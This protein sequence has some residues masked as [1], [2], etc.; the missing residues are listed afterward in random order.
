MSLSTELVVRIG[1]GT[2]AGAAHREVLWKA[3][4]RVVAR[5]RRVFL[6]SALGGALIAIAVGI[7]SAIVLDSEFLAGL[8]V[9]SLATGAAAALFWIADSAAGKHNHRFGTY[10][11]EMTA[12]LFENRRMRN[13]GW[14]VVHNLPFSGLGDVDH[15]AVGPPGVIA[16]ESKWANAIWTVKPGAIS[17]FGDDPTRQ[18]WKSA[19][20]VRRLLATKGVTV[21]PV[22]VL[23]QWGPGGLPDDWTDQ[24]IDGVLVVRR[25]RA[26]A[27]LDQL[28]VAGGELDDET[29]AVALQVLREQRD[30]ARAFEE[31]RSV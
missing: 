21:A 5:N 13:A 18:A 24:W 6:L 8:A 28:G 20:K 12:A 23:V 1:A 27:W 19:D 26:T 14:Q 3:R 25:P 2:T 10:G 7:V 29:R 16:L 31:A 4:R 17:N 30:K 15:I 22:P 11:E 9:G